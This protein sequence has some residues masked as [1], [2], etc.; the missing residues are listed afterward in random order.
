MAAQGDLSAERDLLCIMFKIKPRFLVSEGVAADSR[1][2]GDL[3]I[4]QG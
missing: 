3:L 2:V 1:A 4:C